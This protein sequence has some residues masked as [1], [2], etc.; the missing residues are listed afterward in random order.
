MKQQIF[1]INSNLF[2]QP[3][4]MVLLL[5]SSLCFGAI[6]EIRKLMQRREQ[7]LAVQVNPLETNLQVE[8]PRKI[9]ET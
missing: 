1:T 9:S 6:R 5:L 8:R 2:W 3:F 4:S 7:H